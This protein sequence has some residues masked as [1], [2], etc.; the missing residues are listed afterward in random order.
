MTKIR[1]AEEFLDKGNKL[2]IGLQFRGREMA[3]QEIAAPC[4]NA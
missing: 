2:K 4:S 1:H 3:H